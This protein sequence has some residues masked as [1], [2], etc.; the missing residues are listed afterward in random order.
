MSNV[1]RVVMSARMDE[2]DMLKL[3]RD[4]DRLPCALGSDA[5]AGEE[6]DGLVFTVGVF[7]QFSEVERDSEE[8][9]EGEDLSAIRRRASH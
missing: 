2:V 9:E 6:E 5:E 7:L 4:D 8:G 3:G 1:V